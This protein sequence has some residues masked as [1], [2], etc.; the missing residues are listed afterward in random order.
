M[1]LLVDARGRVLCLYAEAIDL[2]TLGVLAIRR[3]SHVEPDA[4]GRWWADLVPL[5]GPRLGPFARRSEALQAEYT[6]IEAYLFD[7][8][9]PSTP[10]TAD[11]HSRP[12]PEKS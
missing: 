4:A 7:R 3:A 9:P 5:K 1:T 8:A 6:W 11:A 12:E 2:H 10:S